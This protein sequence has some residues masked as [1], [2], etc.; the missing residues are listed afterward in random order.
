MFRSQE[1]TQL[2]WNLLSEQVKTPLNDSNKQFFNQKVQEIHQNSF[3]F[4]DIMEMNKQLIH[5]C[6]LEFNKLNL[7]HRENEIEDMKEG[8]K[9]KE[10]DFS[11][12]SDNNYVNIDVLINETLSKRERDLEEITK[13][14]NTNI[15]QPL[16]G[17]RKKIKIVEEIK[18]KIKPIVEKKVSFNLEPTIPKMCIKINYTENSIN[19]TMFCNLNKHFRLFFGNNKP[20][21]NITTTIEN[22]EIINN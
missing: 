13:H 12:K 21:T 8:F 5:I 16:S 10:I 4:K 6:N 20:Q 3:Q 19:K 15:D 2:I 7:E 14:F 9:P 11:D 1:N 17:E 18:P 22:I